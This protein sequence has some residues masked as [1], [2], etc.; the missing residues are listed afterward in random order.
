MTIFRDIAHMLAR[1]KRKAHPAVS[2]R[3]EC[4]IRSRTP[5]PRYATA[6]KDA[7]RQCTR[8]S[9]TETLE[10]ARLALA[11]VLADDECERIEDG[12]VRLLAYAHIAADDELMRLAGRV[13]RRPRP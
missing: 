8:E 3:Q 1:A 13:A 4:R 7:L 11:S 10:A 5:F 12:I 2:T 6:A 9:S